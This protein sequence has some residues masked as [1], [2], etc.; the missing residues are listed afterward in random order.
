M[1]YDQIKRFDKNS[2]R[3]ERIKTICS[4]VFSEEN[5]FKYGDAINVIMTETGLAMSSSKGIFAQFKSK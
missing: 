2:E 5:A 3:F 1:E 4:S